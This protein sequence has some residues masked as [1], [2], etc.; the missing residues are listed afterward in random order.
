MIPIRDANEAHRKTDDGDV[1]FR[2]AIDLALLKEGRAER[3]KHAS[4]GEP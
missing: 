2:Y 4:V 1:R 3:G